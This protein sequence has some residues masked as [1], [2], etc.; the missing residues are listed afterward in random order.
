[1]REVIQ[2]FWI[3]LT[4]LVLVSCTVGTSPNVTSIA[5]SLP[6]STLQLIFQSE[7]NAE[8]IQ[9][10]EIDNCNGQAYISRVETRSHSVESDVSAEVASKIGASIVAI[11]TEVEAAV[12]A[13]LGSSYER[14]TSIELQAPPETRMRFELRWLGKSRFGRIQNVFGSN[15]PIAF[16]TFIPNDVIV[17]SQVNL[18][19]PTR[20]TYPS[21]N[22][23]LPTEI[24]PTLPASIA[25]HPT[26][27]PTR[28]ITS[29]P[30][31][32]TAQ[33]PTNTPR[34]AT[35]VVPTATPWPTSTSWPTNTSPLST[36]T[37]W[38]SEAPESH[39][40][41]GSFTT[42]RTNQSFPGAP[43]YES[44]IQMAGTYSGFG[45]YSTA[46]LSLNI[47]YELVELEWGEITITV[48]ETSLAAWDDCSPN[49]SEPRI[50]F[51]DVQVSKGE[52]TVNRQM[53]FVIDHNME[54]V[55]VYASISERRVPGEFKIP[56]VSV[57]ECVYLVQ[58]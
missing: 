55:S 41:S 10:F 34:P 28:V 52:G 45:Q 18:G 23:L 6:T 4:T 20:P 44:W 24:Q 30:I 27:P 47:N 2:S 1:M 37:P 29:S 40:L 32:P 16:Q 33:P 21:S 54:S 42:A 14:Q 48:Y 8:E 7:T 50:Y 15:T 43:I 36:P 53:T 57:K 49:Q 19:C 26:A 39:G 56:L 31:Q 51:E 9:A 12:G 13:S 38:P 58:Q 17:K 25:S 22:Q 11:S 46:Y 35:V 3:L 5:Q